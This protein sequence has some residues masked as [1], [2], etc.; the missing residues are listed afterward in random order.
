MR[1]SIREQS[2][3]ILY[4]SVGVPVGGSAPRSTNRD[5]VK[6]FYRTTEYTQER[7]KLNSPKRIVRPVTATGRTMQ[8]CPCNDYLPLV[9]LL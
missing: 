1:I 9:F 7:K 3:I 8:R 4:A 6:G 2:G 5:W